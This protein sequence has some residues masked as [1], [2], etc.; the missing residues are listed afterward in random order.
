MKTDTLKNTMK[1]IILVGR[2]DQRYD[3]KGTKID[4]YGVAGAK[5]VTQL[6]R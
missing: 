5:A 6:D 2:T 1:G 4:A 3:K